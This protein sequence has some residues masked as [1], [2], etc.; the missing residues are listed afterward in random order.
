ML[1]L[2]IKLLPPTG[3][4]W[5]PSNMLSL[6]MGLGGSEEGALYLPLCLRMRNTSSVLETSP[7][8]NFAQ[9]IE[10]A[11]DILGRQ[12]H[13][14]SCSL[15]RFETLELA[16]AFIGQIISGDGGPVPGTV[17]RDRKGTRVEVVDHRPADGSSEAV[18]ALVEIDQMTRTV[19][20]AEAL[21]RD[22]VAARVRTGHRPRSRDLDANI[23]RVA[24]TLTDTQAEV[25]RRSVQRIEDAEE[26]TAATPLPSQRELKTLRLRA[27][28]QPRNTPGER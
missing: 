23:R 3:L 11:A 24:A 19:P 2:I 28:L 10:G 26:E 5:H 20:A 1:R 8:A 22:A 12:L 7:Q 15:D 14:M 9:A 25:L 6:P 21:S 17:F 27:A 13:V 16:I 18:L 4:H